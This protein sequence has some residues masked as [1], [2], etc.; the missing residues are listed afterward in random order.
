[1][2]KHNSRHHPTLCACIKCSC[3]LSETVH[4]RPHPF[5]VRFL[6][7]SAQTFKHKHGTL[8][9]PRVR[10]SP[11]PSALKGCM[12][13]RGGLKPRWPNAEQV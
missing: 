1:M 2:Q 12:R 11:H 9:L 3:L 6:L 10:P 8:P 4:R 5:S 13:D 7:Q